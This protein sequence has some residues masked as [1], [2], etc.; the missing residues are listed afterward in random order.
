VKAARLNCRWNGHAAGSLV[1][2][3]DADAAVNAGRAEPEELPKRRKIT[4]GTSN[5]S[6]TRELTEETQTHAGDRT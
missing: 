4:T 6:P 1:Y 2:G 5:P 3:R